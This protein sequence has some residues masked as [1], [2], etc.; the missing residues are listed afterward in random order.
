MQK[1]LELN[2]TL[3]N[4]LV[5]LRSDTLTKPTA[6]MREAIAGAEV[7]DDV[8][9]EDPTVNKLQNLVAGLLGKEAALFVPSGTMGNQIAINCLTRP[10]DEVICDANSHI[11]N[12]EGGAPALLSGVQIHPVHGQFGHLTAQQVE[13]EI[14]PTDH[15]FA[16]TR[17]VVLENTHNR[18][19]GTI[20]PLEQIRDISHLARAKGLKM[21]LDGAR[22]WNAHVATGIP[23]DDYA[24][25]FDTVSV[26]LSK[27]LGAP[28]GSVL[29]GSAQIIDEAHRFRKLYGGGMRQAG[30][31]AAAGIYAIENNLKRM[32]EDHARAKKLAACLNGFE[33]V[34]VNLDITETNIVIAEFDTDIYSVEKLNTA[35][36]QNGVLGIPFSH[37]KIRFVTHLDLDESDIDLAI[38]IF[39][40][41]IG[42]RTF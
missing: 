30:I 42:E 1:Q 28:V 3:N 40:N 6:A 11:Y 19:G 39:K 24:K 13:M 38:N 27:G 8:F 20:F 34:K 2:K 17:L 35:L 29:T 21:H 32:A 41:I 14:R 15:H 5:D 7:G 33:G 9:A 10:G 16:Q 36:Q 4:K 22:L 23:L 37:S 31:L 12:Y 25:Y 18:A 26:C